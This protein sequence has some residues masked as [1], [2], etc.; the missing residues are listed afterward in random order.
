MASET[1]RESTLL[2]IDQAIMAN[3]FAAKEMV[4]VHA[5]ILTVKFMLVSGRMTKKMEKGGLLVL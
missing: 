1:A 2:L 5:V 4:M 3:G